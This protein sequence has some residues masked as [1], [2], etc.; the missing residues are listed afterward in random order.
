MPNIIKVLLFIEGAFPK[1]I[2]NITD[3]FEECTLLNFTSLFIDAPTVIN[4][5]FKFSKQYISII[6]YSPYNNKF[7]NT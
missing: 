5:G 4:C 1:S 3:E 2:D 7:T 6:Y